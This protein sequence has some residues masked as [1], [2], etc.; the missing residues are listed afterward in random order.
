M[1]VPVLRGRQ[2]S[3]DA[4]PW[5]GYSGD[6]RSHLCGSLGKQ[7]VQLLDRYAG[8]LAKHS[9][10]RTGSVLLELPAHEPDDLPVAVGEIGNAFFARQSW[11]H[12]L[13]PLIRPEEEPLLID[14]NGHPGERLCWA[15]RR[16]GHAF[17]SICGRTRLFPERG[18]VELTPGMSRPGNSTCQY[19]HS[20]SS[21]P[22]WLSRDSSSK[23]SPI[24]LG[25]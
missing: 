22:R 7:L 25:K 1:A 11:N 16:G 6:P 8:G 18:I 20:N 13:C 19:T 17:P 3:L 15:Q 14:V 23:G 4:P 21:L 5:L 12:R 10:G 2:W 9:H 24:R